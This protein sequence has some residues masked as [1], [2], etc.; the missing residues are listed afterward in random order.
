MCLRFCSLSFPWSR[1]WPS[2]LPV[3]LLLAVLGGVGSPSP[4]AAQV[5]TQITEIIDSTGDGFN[6]PESLALEGAGNAYQIPR[7]GA[8]TGRID[9]GDNPFTIPSGLAL[10]E[11]GNA[12]VPRLNRNNSYQITP[13]GAITESIGIGE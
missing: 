9:S 4:T 6:G 8:A 11:A 10:D 5:I 7:A 2:G 3:F 12:Y 13:W 1:R